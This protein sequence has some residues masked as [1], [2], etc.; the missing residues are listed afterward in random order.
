VKFL[1]IGK[2]PGLLLTIYDDMP[3]LPAFWDSLMASIPNYYQYSVVAIDAGSTDGSIDFVKNHGCAVRGPYKDLSVALNK[4]I[5]E[6]VGDLVNWNGEYRY[7]REA[8]SH[9]VW[10]HPDMRFPEVDWLGKLIKHFDAHPDVGKLHPDLIEAPE[11]DR[12]GNQCPWVIP[13]EVLKK[14]QLEIMN[15]RKFPGD[16]SYK[17][18]GW[19]YDEGYAL[20]AGK[21][22]WD[23]NK[24][25]LDLGY[26]VWITG[27]TKISHRSM[28][29]RSRKDN[30]WAV[31]VNY[32][33][34]QKKW[35]RDTPFI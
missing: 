16:P 20:C 22:D 5:W 3:D 12:P 25:I 32:P 2:V 28:G 33:L 8:V 24:R 23:L 10:L 4:G 7:Q 6:F 1:N 27:D 21:E 29:T 30:S 9:V 11:G 14:L 17:Q 34:Y 26:K 13:T 31:N 18:R 15:G 35:G 19:W